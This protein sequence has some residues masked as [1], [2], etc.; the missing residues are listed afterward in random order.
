M[1]ARVVALAALAVL[2]V[3]CGAGPVSIGG[4][5]VDH[6]GTPIQKAEVVTLPETDVSLT[7]SRGF[8]VL[9][10]RINDQGET[11]A[12][13]AGRYTIKVRRFGFEEMAFQVDVEGGPTR[14]PDLIM[15]PRTPDIGEA[16]PD[17]TA[18]PER[19]P[20]ETSTPTLGI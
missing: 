1:V 13:A 16:A 20:D 5:V 17:V 8:F 14:V 6:R 10:Q 2:T 7:N 12:I 18:D 15:K 11:E 19:E 9:R 4:R 3:A